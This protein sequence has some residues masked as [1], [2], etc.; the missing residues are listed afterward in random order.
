[1][2]A[3]GVRP[4]AVRQMGGSDAALRQLY[5]KAALFV[6][7]S[8]YEGFGI[9]PLEAMSFDCPVVCC[10]VASMPEVVGQAACFFEA[11]DVASLRV[12]IER[13]LG[14]A[15]FR[16]ELV[17]RGRDRLKLFSWQRCAEQTLAIYQ[18]V[19]S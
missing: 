8:L 10:D 5:Q 14:D 19:L 3:A 7:P 13:V 2:V 12:A 9:P 6:Y 4:D 1:M 15:N 11:G 18:R 16:N 17:Q